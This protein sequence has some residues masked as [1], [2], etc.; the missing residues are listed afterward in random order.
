[1]NRASWTRPLWLFLC[2]FLISP[3]ATSAWIGDLASDSA[4]A[5]PRLEAPNAPHGW[6][7]DST[8][9]FVVG[10]LEW[11][12]V[13]NLTPFPKKNRRDREFVELFRERFRRAGI[14]ADRIVYLQ[15]RQATQKR[16]D[17]EFSGLLERIPP[18]DTLFVYFCGHGVK[19]EKGDDVFFCG[20]DYDIDAE[21]GWSVRRLLQRLAA[22]PTTGTAIVLADCCHSGFLADTLAA[23]RPRTRIAVCSS[24][25][26][27]EVSTEHWTFTEAVLGALNGAAWADLDGDRLVTLEEFAVLARGDL[28]QFE[29]QRAT[30]GRSDSFPQG[31]VLATGAKPARPPVGERLEAFVDD[32]WWKCRVIE[33]R[34]SKI[35]VHYVGYDDED[36]QWIDRSV[37]RPI[38]I[39]RFPVGADVQV[40]WEEKWYKARILREEDGVHEIAYDGYGSEW[41]EWA[42]PARIRL[43]QA[44]RGR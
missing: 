1:M 19:S 11:R 38:T 10:V 37:T 39:K 27:S 44:R 15:D 20:F 16:I 14:P 26:A 3:F 17:A 7:P 40:L 5:M 41:N 6:T 31:Y 23:L 32:T 28:G 35:K 30:I 42:S 24:S 22:R 34:D 12:D 2:L 13:E 4:Q 43:P 18:S 36:D 29:A 21:N 33:A 25:S 9:V 8:W